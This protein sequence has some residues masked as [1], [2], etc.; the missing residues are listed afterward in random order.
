MTWTPRTPPIPPQEETGVW[1]PRT[2]IPD[3][4]TTGTWA[5][6]YPPDSDEYADTYQDE[7]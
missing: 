6:R 2:N 4:D 7:Y 1:T 3:H 5:P